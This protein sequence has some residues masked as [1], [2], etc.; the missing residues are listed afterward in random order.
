LGKPKRFKALDISVKQSVVTIAE[1]IGDEIGFKQVTIEPNLNEGQADI[2]FIDGLTYHLEVK[3][4][5][6]GKYYKEFN[7]LNY[8]I[9]KV[10]SANGSQL[11]VACAVGSELIPFKVRQIDRQDE[12][13]SMGIIEYCSSFPPTKAVV[14]KARN[15]LKEAN[16]QLER[17][18]SKYKSKKIFVLDVTSYILKNEMDFREILLQEYKKNSNNLKSLDGIVIFSFDPS[19]RGHSFIPVFLSDGLSTEVFKRSTKANPGNSIM[20]AV[21]KKT[22]K[23]KGKILEIEKSGNI[24]ID[25]ISYGNFFEYLNIPEL[26][27][28]TPDNNLKSEGIMFTHVQRF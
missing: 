8:K 2:E 5:N 23:E 1:I 21:N 20:I 15:G 10:L 3:T 17:I 11:V 7:E 12:G 19:T 28:K 13:A 24:K 16:E 27:S 9:R 22:P 4:P 6:L 25:D 18:S 14:N 26:S